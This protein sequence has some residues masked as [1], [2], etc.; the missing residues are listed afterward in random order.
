VAVYLTLFSFLSWQLIGSCSGIHQFYHHQFIQYELKHQ[1]YILDAC[2]AL[3]LYVET[4][5]DFEQNIN[6]RSLTA[7]LGN[8]GHN[9]LTPNGDVRYLPFYYHSYAMT[10]SL[11]FYV[12]AITKHTSFRDDYFPHCII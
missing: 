2:I 1:L 6:S 8:P 11:C 4:K 9:V 12:P 10:L 3:N 5:M 7:L